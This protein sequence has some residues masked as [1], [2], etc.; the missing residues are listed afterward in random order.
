MNRPTA[1]AGRP[2]FSGRVRLV[3]FC[4]AGCRPNPGSHLPVVWDGKV[5][6]DAPR[7]EGTNHRASYQSVEVALD[8][9]ARQ[10][11]QHIEV[12]LTSRLV[13]LQLTTGGYCR[14][15]D[16]KGLRD[17]IFMLADRVSP[18]R[19]VL[20]EEPFPLGRRVFSSRNELRDHVAT[21]FS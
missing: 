15:I 16:L 9:A 7:V 20:V 8:D 10:G 12:Q 4:D 21:V 17:L 18:I 5:F 14:D 19:T 6:L 11:A 1:I 3:Y 2:T 13:F